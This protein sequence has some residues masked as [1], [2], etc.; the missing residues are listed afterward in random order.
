M[1]IPPQPSTPDLSPDLSSS[2]FIVLFNSLVPPSVLDEILLSEAPRNSGKPKITYQQLSVGLV[3]QA[4][5]AKGTLS[6]HIEELYGIR[7]SDAALSGRK[8]SIGWEYAAMLLEQVLKP[9]AIPGLHPDAFYKGFRLVAAD[10]TKFDLQNTPAI[11]DQVTKAN[12]PKGDGSKVA[13]GQMNCEVLV[14]LGMF[15]PLSVALS[16]DGRGELTLARDILDALPETSLLLG[17]RLYGSPWFLYQAQQKFAAMSS[18]YLVRVKEDLKINYLETLPDGSRL[19]KVEVV[20]PETKRKVGVIK[21]REIRARVHI[22]GDAAASDIRLWTSL[23][24]HECYPAL[25]LA[26]LYARRWS[27]E[28]FYR[29]VKHDLH[30]QDSLLKAQSIHGAALEVLS[31]MLAA[32]LTAMQRAAVAG[33]ANVSPRKV[34]FSVVLEETRMLLSLFDLTTGFLTKAQQ[35][36]VVDRYWKKLGW[37]ALIKPRKSRR[38]QRGKRKT[39]SSWRKISE[40]TSEPLVVSYEIL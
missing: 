22:E 38:C 29:E 24:D 15:N 28:L 20:D 25:E 31:L 8:D 19:G 13:F 32:A 21:V 23:L 9:I 7:V 26:A 39:I 30:G 33:Q 35:A 17:D 34:S 4:L 27:Q 1:P 12:S 6:M 14:E 2:A 10:L 37:K 40:P 18:H 5:Y 11:L 16:W 36:E 3:R